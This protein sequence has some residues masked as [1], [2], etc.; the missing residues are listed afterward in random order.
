M[1]NDIFRR[2]GDTKPIVFQLW[3]DKAAGTKLDIT[4][5][6]FRFTVDPSDEPADAS[7][8][9]FTLTHTVVGLEA[10]GKIMFAPSAVQMDITPDTYY[11]DFEITDAEGYIDTPVVLKFVVGQDLSK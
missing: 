1:S 10:D 2:R 7:N 3:E 8:N 9:L 11:Y 6:A 4:G 5:F